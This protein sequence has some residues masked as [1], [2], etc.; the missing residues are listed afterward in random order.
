MHARVTVQT[1]DG[2]R[3]GAIKVEKGKKTHRTIGRCPLY[4]EDGMGRKNLELGYRGGRGGG[5]VLWSGKRNRGG[6]K[7][8]GRDGGNQKNRGKGE[9]MTALGSP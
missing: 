8:G 7:R 1:D 2:D 6:E 5:I 4:Y 9:S 3:G